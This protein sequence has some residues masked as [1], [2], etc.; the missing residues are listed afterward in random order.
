MISTRNLHL[1]LLCS[2]LFV[3][4]GDALASQ[5][6]RPTS[7]HYSRFVDT[8][9]SM[10]GKSVVVTG[11][12]RGLGYVTA[13]VLVEKG[14]MVYMLNRNNDK[15]IVDQLHQTNTNAPT[16][17]V[18][19]CD[20]LDFS[21]VRSAAAE[22]RNHV[23]EQGGGIDVLCNN[24]GI[25]LQ[26]DQS[27]VDG[28]DITASTNVLSHFLL[29]KELF[30]ELQNAAKQKGDARIVN[31]SSASGYGP[32]PFN[33]QFLERRGG[34]CGGPQ[35]SYERYHQSKLGNLAFTA[36]LDDRLRDSN[37]SIKALA[38]TPGVCGTD[39]YLHATKAMFGKASSLENMPSPEDGSMAQLKCICDPT[40]SGRDLWGPAMRR[41]G[42][43]EGE[44]VKTAIEAP[45]ILVD[46]T[47][48]DLFWSTC[49][50]AV[51]KF[52]I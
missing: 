5:Q 35:A 4:F 22:I 19:P 29:T 45:K 47:V 41:G 32:S 33:P 16:P 21:S 34:N 15:S 48:K 28:Y 50:D 2:F 40:V 46:D 7:L 49:E 27:S 9:P 17:M 43:D 6:A 36:A 13:K 3:S 24:A 39:M 42:N 18:I 1:L 37:N 11:C 31:M 51:G 30:G 8:L 38:C 25:M 26:P 52:N 10:E 23:A 12:S 44:L 14:A 20:L